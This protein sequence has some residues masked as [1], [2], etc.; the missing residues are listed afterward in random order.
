[1]S[2]GLPAA[3][4]LALPPRRGPQPPPWLSVGRRGRALRE[5]WRSLGKRVEALAVRYPR[6][7]RRLPDDW[8][9]E[10]LLSEQLAALVSWRLRL[11]EGQLGADERSEIAFHQALEK[12]QALLDARAK[13][14][15]SEDASDPR[16][17]GGDP[18]D[19]AR[20]AGRR[21]EALV[22]AIARIPERAGVTPADA[23]L[24]PREGHPPALG[25]Q[26]SHNNASRS[27]P[28]PDASGEG[29]P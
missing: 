26:P 25:R 17:P 9:A 24:T 1:V 22:G 13:A 20:R 8:W 2:E 16:A 11:D 12:F 18:L 14:V 6:A 10:P 27:A 19:H 23:F 29:G 5:W 15:L 21:Q 3:A 4:P 7:L 28:P